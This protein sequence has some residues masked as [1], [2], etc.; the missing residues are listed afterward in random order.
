MIFVIGGAYQGKTEY[1]KKT[2]PDKNITDSYHLEVKKQL[3]KG[4]NPM[5]EVEKLLQDE[6]LDSMVIVSNDIGNGL[7]PTD[8]FERGYREMVGRV[9]CAIAA[10]AEQVIRIICGIPTRIK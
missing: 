9:N 1:V 5:A 3:E 10:E 4:E 8:D 7:V 2:F 6:A